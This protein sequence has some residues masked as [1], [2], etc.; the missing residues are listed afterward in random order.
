VSEAAVAA[1]AL[2]THTASPGSDPVASIPAAKTRM[3]ITIMTCR[4]EIGGTFAGSSL[5]RE[6][7]IQT[8]FGIEF[9]P[10]L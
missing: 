10:F 1:S 5:G 4:I 7:G 9:C 3:R 6:P 8:C 2:V